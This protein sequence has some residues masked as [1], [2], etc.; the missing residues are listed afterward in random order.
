LPV[1]ASSSS[2]RPKNWWVVA[3]P[4]VVLAKI[5]LSKV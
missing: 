5:V 3:A 4:G 1:T 2:D